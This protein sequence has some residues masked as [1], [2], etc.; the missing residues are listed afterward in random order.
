MIIDLQVSAPGAGGTARGLAQEGELPM[1]SQPT[2]ACLT[3]SPAG[4][5]VVDGY[6]IRIRVER[7][8]LLI[9][10][11][12]GRHRRAGRFPRAG[13]SL[14]RLVVLGHTGAVSLDALRWLADTGVGYVV[15]DPDGRLLAAS[16]NLGRDD[17]RLRRAQAVAIDSPAGD[18]I[19]RRLIA[20]KIAGQAET[21][22]AVD[23]IAPVGEATIAA[24]REAVGRLHVATCRDEIRQA[25][26]LAAAAYWSAWVSVPVRFARR[27][28]GRI[29][30]AWTTFGPRS[31]PLT[32]SPRLAVRPAQACFNFLYAILEAEARLACLAVG[33][34][35]G[36]GVLHSDLK[37]RDSLALDVMEPV[38]PV[39]DRYVL[40]VITDRAFRATD[41]VET[42]QGNVRVLAPLSHE[43]AATMLDWRTHIGAVTERVAALLVSGGPG[44]SGRQPTPLTGANRSAGRG[45]SARRRPRTS[46]E[47]RTALRACAQCGETVPADRRLC[48]QCLPTDRAEQAAGFVAA[49]KARL[50]ELRAAGVKPGIGG[51]AAKARGTKL[52]ASCAAARAWERE[53]PKPSDPDEFRRD[54]LPRLAGLTPKALAAATGLSRAYCSAILRG[55]RVPHPRWWEPLMAAAGLVPGAGGG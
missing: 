24:L 25:E 21:L 11:G 33:L 38:R 45:P 19:A 35:P 17:P 5:L 43:L 13:S 39:I 31:S 41:F 20:E 29:P 12:I 28:L 18:D 26:A 40:R 1:Q 3:P 34:D 53:H 50:A 14:R 55:E 23:Q 8:Q 48:G 4:V 46:A 54:V 9:A 44:S 36:L 16:G 51:A 10:D 22:T 2:A 42:R 6:G 37:A 27:D 15:L 52:A 7:G 49:G 47:P 30:D 32:A